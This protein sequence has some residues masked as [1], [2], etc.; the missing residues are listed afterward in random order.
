MSPVVRISPEGLLPTM[1]IHLTFTMWTSFRV[2]KRRWSRSRIIAAA[3]AAMA[4]AGAYPSMMC[5]LVLVAV[6]MMICDLTVPL[7]FDRII[8]HWPRHCPNRAKSSLMM[9]I[10]IRITSSVG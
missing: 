4:A 8:A 9:N 7:T 3:A 1:I 6:T 10:R 2:R 5:P